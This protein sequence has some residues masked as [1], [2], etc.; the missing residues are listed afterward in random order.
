MPLKGIVLGQPGL[1]EA[2]KEAVLD[3]GLKA[4]VGRGTGA[5][6]RGGERVPLAAGAQHEK[7]G[8]GAQ[9]VRHAGPSAPK[10]VGVFMLR[11]ERFHQGPQLVADPEAPA[12]T[13]NALGPGPGARLDF[14]GRLHL[15]QRYHKITYPDRLLVS[16]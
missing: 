15:S 9:A 16:D 2:L 1:P 7:D 8:V 10:A 12:G 5:E 4:V 14:F 13:R 3:P 11:Q 6:A